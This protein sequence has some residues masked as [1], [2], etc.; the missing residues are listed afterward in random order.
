MEGKNRCIDIKKKERCSTKMKWVRKFN[1]KEHLFI[2][3]YRTIEG[4]EK[5]KQGWEKNGYQVKIIEGI[6]NIHDKSYPDYRF[7]VHDPRNRKGFR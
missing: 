4:A 5:D 2:Q 3:S 6:Q 1:G 7:Y